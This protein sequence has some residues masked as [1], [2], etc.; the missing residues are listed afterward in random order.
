MQSIR[1]MAIKA[2]QRLRSGS[3]AAPTAPY[4]PLPDPLNNK[5]ATLDQ[6]DRSHHPLVGKAV[7]AAKDWQVRRRSQAQ[8]GETPN[9]SLVL[10]ADKFLVKGK[11]DLNRTGYGCGKTHIAKAVLW[12][13]CYMRDDGEPVAPVGQFFTSGEVIRDLDDDSSVRTALLNRPIVVIDDVG[14]EGELEFIKG[15]RQDKEVQVRYFRVINF[16]YEHGVS[17]VITANMSL[18]QLGEYVGGRCWSRL[19][20]MAP[21]GFMVDMT[22][23]PDYRRLVSGRG[24]KK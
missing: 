10:V 7:A 5:R 20:E 8:A 12:S 23:V 21:T 13:M 18:D 4:T 16:C 1:D 3:A 9:A 6:L 17:V 15:E 14:A 11:A 22:G 24:V 19:L 2:T